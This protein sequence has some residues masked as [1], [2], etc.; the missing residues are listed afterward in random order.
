M[1][2]K[3]DDAEMEAVEEESCIIVPKVLNFGD[4]TDT[5]ESHVRF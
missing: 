1:V 2:E 4:N 5:K 3:N